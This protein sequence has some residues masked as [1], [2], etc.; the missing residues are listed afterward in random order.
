MRRPER[1]GSPAA[2]G[3]WPGAWPLGAAGLH[4]VLSAGPRARRIPPIR[5]ASRRLRNQHFPHVFDYPGVNP[6]YG[7]LNARSTQEVLDSSGSKVALTGADRPKMFWR[8]K[9][10]R[11][12]YWEA[13]ELGEHRLFNRSGDLAARI[14]E[15]AAIDRRTGEPGDFRDDTELPAESGPALSGNSC[16]VLPVFS[17]SGPASVCRPEI[18]ASKMRLAD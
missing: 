10:G 15:L 9:A 6:A 12:W 14:N 1:A 16:V 8:D 11:G 13:D 2:S 18:P 17:A 4:A 5:S 7:S 3:V